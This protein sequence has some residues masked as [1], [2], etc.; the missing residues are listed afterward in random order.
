MKECHTIEK[1]VDVSVI[2]TVYNLED[3]IGECLDSLLSQEGVSLEVICVDDAS[4]DNS[5]AVLMEYAK[6]DARVK[7]IRNEKNM[8]LASSRNV[9]FRSARGKYL[10]N[11]DGDDYLKAGALEKL[12]QCSE[13][14]HLDLLGFSAISFYDN[15]EMRK[16]GA[17]DEYVR[18]GD[19]SKVT[20]GAE[21][22]AELIENNDRASSNLVLYFYRRDYFRQNNLYSVEG[23]RYADDSMFKM[24]IAAK[25]A[26]CI[27]DQLYMRR[28][29]EGSVCTSPMK[30]CYMESMIVL[31]L[32]E[33]RVWQ[34]ANLREDLNEKIE[35][36]FNTRQE[37]IRSFHNSFRN[38]D[39]ETELLNKNIMAKYFYKYFIQETP[40]YNSCFTQEEMEALKKEDTVILYGAG[41]I[42]N[43][44]A[45]VFEAHNIEDYVVAVTNKVGEK[46][47]R[48]KSVFGIQELISK[49]DGMV[50]VAMTKKNHEAVVETLNKLG[51]ARYR[52][53]VF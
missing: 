6:K 3:Y 50:I 23:L 28:Y 7:V 14:N 12:Y 34:N 48:G 15:E 40:L 29:R 2:V 35:R 39:S 49:R 32:E 37:S 51:F 10:Y 11:I 33:L 43:E 1:Q 21:L 19:Y 8:G 5:Y 46:K 18:K 44:V 47:F 41:Y 16:F 31:F 52:L 27:P 30:K 42:G 26:M 22:F 45:K 53:V 20:S 17:E 13:E 4:K 24:Y 38:D 9:G 36:Y 25:R